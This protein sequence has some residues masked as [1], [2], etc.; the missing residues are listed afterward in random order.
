MKSCAGSRSAPILEPQKHRG[1][2]DGAG[3][4]GPWLRAF[5]ALMGDLGLVP[6]THMVAHK[7][8][9]FQFQGIQGPLLGLWVP[10]MHV[11]AGKHSY[12]LFLSANY[13]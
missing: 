3:E 2:E 4:M 8:S 12:I 7:H 10:G 1:A 5:V 6:C 13:S 11:V 9:E